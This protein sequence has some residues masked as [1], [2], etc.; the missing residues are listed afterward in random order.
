MREIFKRPRV[1]PFGTAPPSSSIGTTSGEASVDPVGGGAAAIP[2][3]PTLDDFD[4][5]CTLETIMTVQAAHGQILV[6]MLDEQIW[7]IFDVLLCHLLLMMDSDCPLA[8][9]HKKGG[10]LLDTCRVFFCS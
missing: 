1:D 3:P 9:H 4:I 6:D 10:V 7:R 8:F 5:C 2:P